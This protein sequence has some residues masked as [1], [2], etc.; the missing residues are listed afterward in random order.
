VDLSIEETVAKVNFMSHEVFQVTG[1]TQKRVS[2]FYRVERSENML[3][4]VWPCKD[5]YVAFMI[6]GG[7]WGATHD[8]PWMVKW[9]DEAGLADDF[10][11]GIDWMKLNWR[12]STPEE[13]KKIHSYIGKLFMTLTKDEILSEALKRRIAIQP[14]NAPVD[15]LKH[16]QLKFRD[17]WQKVEYPE[18][19]TALN[20]PAYAFKPSLSP[21]K[22]WC[23]APRIGEH[24]AAVF[25]KEMGFSPEKLICLKQAGII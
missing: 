19:G 21:V 5:G 25:G 9:I 6:F 4:S 12:K 8:N 11:R 14:I 13:V 20:Y 16:E 23:A 24:N 17:Y 1:N 3:Q 2:S 22:Q 7:N 15:I 18:L 10:L